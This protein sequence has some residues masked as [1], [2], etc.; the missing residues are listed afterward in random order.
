MTASLRGDD[1]ADDL[2][3]ELRRLN[4]QITG[5]RREIAQ[6]YL[7]RA[8]SRRLRRRGLLLVGVLMVLLLAGGWVTSRVTLAREHRVVAECFLLPSRLQPA[9]VAACSRTFPGYENLQ[10]QSAQNL[11]VFGDLRRRVAELEREVADLKE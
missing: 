3:A 5:L 9:R 11:Q 4:D 2:A 6:N 8:E 10:R 1:V 7:P